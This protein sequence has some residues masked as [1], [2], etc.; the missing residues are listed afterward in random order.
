MLLSQ[1]EV[2]THGFWKKKKN[3]QSWASQGTLVVKNLPANAGDVGVIPGVGRSPGEGSGTHCSVL[4]GKP[5]GQRSLAGYSPCS[6]RESD[7]TEHTPNPLA[8]ARGP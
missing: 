2:S 7:V 3:I 6:H 1:D 4:A 5:R 8:N